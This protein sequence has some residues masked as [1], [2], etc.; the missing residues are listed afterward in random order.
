MG[1]IVKFDIAQM[2]GTHNVD[3]RQYSLA[4]GD[5]H[6]ISI[7]ADRLNSGA[8]INAGTMAGV[9]ASIIRPDSVV[10][11]TAVID[12]GWNQDRG[13]YVMVFRNELP[14]GAVED[15]Y[16]TGY[17]SHMG[18][19][20]MASGLRMVLDPQMR[21][22]IDNIT[23][24]R[25]M[26]QGIGMAGS[27]RESSQVLYQPYMPGMD[28]TSQAQSARPVDLFNTL[29]ENYLPGDTR[30]TFI[31]GVKLSG[32]ENN[33]PAH[34]MAKTLQA[35][36]NSFTD[37][38]S[39]WKSNPIHNAA[40]LVQETYTDA[41]PFLL[42][43]G[44]FTQFKQHGFVTWGELTRMQS[45]LDD[46]TRLVKFDAVRA[47]PMD[48]D[49][50]RG[51]RNEDIIATMVAQGAPAIMMSLGITSLTFKATNRIAGGSDIIIT[52]MMSYLPSTDLS[53][54]VEP[55]RA[56]FK[57][58]LLYDASNSDQIPYEMDGTL[59]LA[60]FSYINVNAGSGMGAIPFAVPTICGSLIAPTVVRNRLSLDV[61]SQSMESLI[62]QLPW[63]TNR[64]PH[65]MVPGGLAVPGSA[66]APQ[67]MPSLTTGFGAGV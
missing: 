21:F 47:N 42:D 8:G 1:R 22:Y 36:S 50:M 30:G 16:V 14:G 54:Y 19:I 13:R 32:L 5:G 37:A 51:S 55:V 2:A 31:N 27:I 52:N 58:T 12:G 65:H 60:G 46:L 33:N 40:S 44:R 18:A 61:L 20:S 17:T 25:Y 45:D 62:N 23:V 43:L 56:K 11:P 4:G 38:S 35:A 64:Q 24:M 39:G 49:P 29:G 59:D 10:G 26:P 6:A 48:C 28:I 7:L 41:N 67:Q 53:I 57:T 9:A 63:A 34:F 15:H 3:R 66:S